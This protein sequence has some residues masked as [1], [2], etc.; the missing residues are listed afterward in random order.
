[1]LDES[2]QFSEENVL[3]I[4]SRLRTQAKMKPSLWLTCNP[5]PTSFIRRWIDWWIIPQGEENAGRPDPERDG[6]IRWFIRDSNEMIWADTREELLEKYGNRDLNGNLIPDESEHQHCRPLSLQFI[7][8]TIFDNP[9]LL[10]ANPGYLANLQGLKRVKRE[11]D[12]YGKPIQ[13]A[14]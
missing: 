9:P 8:A 5:S 14:A 10:R 11:R 13:I 4:L 7:S 2:T 3:V 6:K 1:M 12:L